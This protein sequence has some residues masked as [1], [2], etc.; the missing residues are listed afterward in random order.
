MVHQFKNISS[1]H[2][3]FHPLNHLDA[4]WLGA[5]TF[6]GW[7][8][9]NSSRNDKSRALQA[10]TPLLGIYPEDTFECVPDFCLSIVY[11][12]KTFEAT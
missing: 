5:S 6:C 10:A 2:V 12:T 7:Q 9:G 4:T 3:K 1:T 8:Y 11:K